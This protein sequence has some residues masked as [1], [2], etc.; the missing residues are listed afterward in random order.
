MNGKL[1]GNIIWIKILNMK[2][3][4]LYNIMILGLLFFVTCQKPNT[5]PIAEFSIYPE[6]GDTTNIFTFNASDSD[7]NEDE[8]SILQVHWDWDGDGIWDTDLS[9]NKVIQHQ[10]SK[11]GNYSATLEVKDSEG[12]LNSIQK[13]IIVKP[14]PPTVITDSIISIGPITAHGG[15]YVTNEG[16]GEVTAKGVCWSMEG[17]PDLEDRYTND[18]NDFGDFNSIIIDLLPNKN[19][20][21]RAYAT[22]SVGTAYGNQVSFATISPITPTLNTTTITNITHHTAQGGGIITDDGGMAVTAKGVCWSVE[23]NPDLEDRYTNNGHGS[24]EF[25]SI[26]TNL[27]PNTH[28]YVRA[29]ATS[30][31]GTAYGDQISFTSLSSIIQW[32]KCFGGS[33]NDGANSIQLTADGGYIVAGNTGSTDG[34]VLGFHGGLISDYWI[35][36]L[37]NTGTIQWQKCLGGSGYDNA[38][39]IQQTTDRGFIIG[40]TTS[41]NDG[42]VSGNHGR[43]DYWI[44][45]LSEAGNI[46]WQKCLGGSGNET[47]QSIQQT[48]DEGY[49]IAGFTNSKDGNVSGFHKGEYYDSWIVK[50]DKAG[51][52]QW[53][54]CLGGGS[55]EIAWS[56]Q[57]TNNGGY[58]IAGET[59][60]NDGDVTGNHGEHDIWIVKLDEAGNIQWQKCLGGSGSDYSKSIQQTNDGGYIVAGYTKSNDGDVTGNHGGSDIWIVKLDEAGNIQWQKCLGGSSYDQAYSIQQTNDG[61]YII[62]GETS[63]YDG[64]IIDYRELGYHY[65]H[66]DSWIVKLNEVG[67]IQWQKC[68]GGIND[69]RASSI[70]QTTDGGYIIAG[71]T[72]SK[73]GDVTGNHGKR[74][75]WIIKIKD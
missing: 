69:D 7:D 48:N 36:K 33:S 26:L 67:N 64:D 40:G 59:Y 5:P 72:S 15:G 39:S 27:S 51:N 10:Y 24:G 75:V 4:R 16:S 52:I 44:V 20:Y 70:Q 28:Y 8:S 13:I 17:N 37:N 68:L 2:D 45:K 30:L 34:D 38:S 32:Q 43:S 31:V 50:L 57:Q 65:H 22:S 35:V 62:A 46:Q 60:S 49:I 73:D 56:I 42:H 53:Q 25:T 3:L 61:G 12:L 6:Y 29:Y 21:V 55:Q 47:A 71:D 1:K 54:K 14:Y 74:D 58:I 19:Y 11:R 18:G 23:E 9:T 66:S 41:S 63:S